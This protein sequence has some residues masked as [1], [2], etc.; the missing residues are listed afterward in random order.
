M[1]PP[2]LYTMKILGLGAPGDLVLAEPLWPPLPM[3]SQE[4]RQYSFEETQMLVRGLSKHLT[5][6]LPREG[7]HPNQTGSTHAPLLL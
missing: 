7:L 5:H 4:G 3:K 1:G 2:G 6:S